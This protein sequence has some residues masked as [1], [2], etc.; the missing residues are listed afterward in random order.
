MQESHGHA[1]AGGCVRGSKGFE[2][3]V[4]DGEEK[5]LRDRIVLSKNDRHDIDVVVD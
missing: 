2:K 4:I 3:V 5:S 1:M